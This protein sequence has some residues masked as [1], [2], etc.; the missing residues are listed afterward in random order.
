MA[1]SSITSILDEVT[2]S[3]KSKKQPKRGSKRQSQTE[4]D[5]LTQRLITSSQQALASQAELFE[6]EQA[7]SKFSK[8]ID[9]LG[10]LDP[11]IAYSYKMYDKIN[12]SF[13]GNISQEQYVNQFLNTAYK[14]KFLR[15][16]LSKLP[17]DTQIPE[18]QLRQLNELG[19]RNPNEEMSLASS[20][21]TENDDKVEGGADIISNVLGFLQGGIDFLNQGASGYSQGLYKSG[22]KSGR[23]PDTGKIRQGET[24]IKEDGT[25]LEAGED[26]SLGVARGVVNRKGEVVRVTGISQM[27]QHQLSTQ[28]SR[29]SNEDAVRKKELTTQIDLNSDRIKKQREVST[30]DKKNQL[31]IKKD[32]IKENNNLNKGNID[33]KSS[34]ER[35]S[36]M[37]GILRTLR[38]DYGITGALSGGWVNMTK[39]FLETHNVPKKLISEFNANR[40]LIQA[41]I[42]RD[43]AGFKGV[44]SDFELQSL[45]AAIPS[46]VGNNAYDEGVFN[47]LVDSLRRAYDGNVSKINYNNNAI[48]SIDQSV[49]PKYRS[50]KEFQQ[51]AKK[52][53]FEH[54]TFGLVWDDTYKNPDGTLGRYR[55][56][57]Y[58]GKSR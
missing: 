9:K 22:V 13:G 44:L 35:I 28:Y 33:L 4:T 15:N 24:L 2:P 23:I 29:M 1:Q 53:N 41:F 12:Q 34:Y 19:I 5:L 46:L 37:S 54:G 52:N 45:A 40:G 58:G 3:R 18:E 30:A 11:N 39:G 38:D 27:T 10:D 36:K 14:K 42:A 20:D 7:S 48:T 47:A 55:E 16:Q 31:S 50:V 25:P 32:L 6:A 26:I 21:M 56:A 51:R 43:L 57:Y 49:A 8:L 17:N